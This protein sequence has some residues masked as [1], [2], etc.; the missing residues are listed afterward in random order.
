[1]AGL[2]ALV[3]LLTSGATASL[4]STTSLGALT[5]DVAGATAAVAGLLGLRRSALTADVTLLAAVVASWGTLGRAV[6]SAVRVVSAVVAATATG[7]GSRSLVVH[8]V[9][10]FEW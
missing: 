10:V 7:S 6:G 3:A 1:V 8:C 4:G 5:G 2:A 9:W